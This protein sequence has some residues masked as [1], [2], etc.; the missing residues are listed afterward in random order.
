MTKRTKIL[1]FFAK[2]VYYPFTTVLAHID[3]L[4]LPCIRLWSQDADAYC[5]SDFCK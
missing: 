2:R 5:S 3:V 4:F 1:K